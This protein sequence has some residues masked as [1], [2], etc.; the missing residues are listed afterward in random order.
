MMQLT[1]FHRD[2]AEANR[3]SSDLDK[4]IDRDSRAAAGQDYATLTTLAVRQVFAATQLV[5]N[6]DKVHLFLKE[7]S[8]NGNCQTIDVIYPA[9]PMFLY[10]NA[11]LIR[12]LLE[13]HF[14]NQ[15]SGHWP[16]RW[17]IHDL[18]SSYPNATGHPDGRAEQMP[19][20]QSGNH[21]IMMLA[22]LQRTG[23][24]DFVRNHYPLLQQW[25]H[26]AIEDSLFPDNQL[27]TDDFHQPM[28][29]QTNLA[30]KG[31]VGLEAMAVLASLVG[32]KQDS[33]NYSSIA[34]DYIRQWQDHAIN[35]EDNPPHALI[36]YNDRNT[37]GLLYNLYADAL[38]GL[39]L[40]PD[41][42]YQMQT[43]LYSFVKE[44]YGVPLDTRATFT[45]SDWAMFAAAAATDIQT[46][47]MIIHRMAQWVA[48]TSD[49]RPF[50]DI[51][52]TATGNKVA[53]IDFRA[54]PVMGGMF[55]LLAMKDQDSGIKAKTGDA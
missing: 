16:H 20:E 35:R 18:G 13:P 9:M 45:K 31:M 49:S 38:L 7:I 48:E 27:S 5:G 24:I 1:Y 8:S 33:Q 28:E 11:D 39:H 51:Y 40:V 44:K 41:Y 21:L 22:Y 42:V 2:F 25:A 3:L 32:E 54:R 19:L 29:N 17:P 36:T 14:E 34:H 12:L 26:Y 23:D 4:K 15:E 55:S 10:L 52:E 47:D 37:H 53:G 43:H 30:L 46:R 6:T 50:T